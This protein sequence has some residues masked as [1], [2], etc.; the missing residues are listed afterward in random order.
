MGCSGASCPRARRR[1]SSNPP[2]PPAS[3]NL[4]ATSWS[5]MVRR[6]AP[7]SR[8]FDRPTSMPWAKPNPSGRP[9]AGTGPNCASAQSRTAPAW[10]KRP[11]K[12][13]LARYFHRR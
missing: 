2:P 7:R 1:Q 9:C 8:A 5:L 10:G 6:V 11:S 12:K 13:A 4:A 3:S